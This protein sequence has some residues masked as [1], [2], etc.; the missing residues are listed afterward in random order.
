VKG[1]AFGK[2]FSANQPHSQMN[3]NLNCHRIFQNR[4]GKHPVLIEKFCR[5]V[6]YQFS[7]RFSGKTVFFFKQRLFNL[8]FPYIED[9]INHASVVYATNMTVL[10]RKI[11]TV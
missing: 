8:K 10:K 2:R 11:F 9:K 1:Y 7:L 5:Q 6:K 4:A 3:V